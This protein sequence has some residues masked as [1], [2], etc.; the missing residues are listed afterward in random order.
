MT[1]CADETRGMRGWFAVRCLLAVLMTASCVQ[2]SFQHGR[3]IFRGPMA[4]DAN[5]FVDGLARLDT[6]YRTGAWGLIASLTQDP[7]HAPFSSLLAMA[8]FAVFGRHAWA[9]Y[10]GNGI[11]ILALLGM[12]DRLLGS[13]RPWQR[14]MAY[15]LVLATRLPSTAV[16]EFRPDVAA[17][18][19]TAFAILDGFRYPIINAS[20]ARRA[21]LGAFFG[22]SLLL[23]PSMA[24]VNG[25]LFAATLFVAIISE[26]MAEGIRPSPRKIMDVL[27]API[28]TAIL[29]SLPYYAFGWRVTFDYIFSNVFGQ[30]KGL[31]QFQGNVWQHLRYYYD[32][33][34]HAGSFL[35]GVPHAYLLTVLG[36]VGVFLTY[37]QGSR[38]ARFRLIGLLLVAVLALA[39]PTIAKTKNNFFGANF[40]SLLLLGGVMA[41]RRLLISGGRGGVGIFVTAF[42]ASVFLLQPPVSRGDPELSPTTFT[43]HLIDEVYG[44]VQAGSMGD[45]VFVPAPGTMVSWNTMNYLALI[46]RSGR[47]F[48]NLDYGRWDDATVIDSELDQADWVVLGDPGNDEVRGDLPNGKEG[49]ALYLRA[50][51]ARQEFSEVATFSAWAAD[52]RYHIFRRTTPAFSGFE[53]DAAVGLTPADGPHPEWHRPIVRYARDASTRLKFKTL[54]NGKT[55]IVLSLYGAQEGQGLKVFIDG[56]EVASTRL[57]NDNACHDLRWMGD[58]MAGNHDLEIRYWNPPIADQTSPLAMYKKIQIFGAA[59]GR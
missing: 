25:L 34:N 38:Q 52:H 49:L 3:L 10:A 28:L 8:S 47:R 36:A 30:R 29:V 21:R 4:D 35:L 43:N 51:A 11:I 46:D 45:R 23:K 42:V 32:L 59:P 54:N 19:V 40:Q 44:S 18:L 24:P 58:L 1:Q 37:R 27:T 15:A 56:R 14:G 13:V 12:V 41:L 48:M 50:V 39:I 31:W 33:P 53:N 7:P 16:V 5:Y 55:V 22:L 26:L 9:P 2:Y 57:E 20:T 17:G 6:F